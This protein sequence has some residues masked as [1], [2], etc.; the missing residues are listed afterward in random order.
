MVTVHPAEAPH[1]LNNHGADNPRDL[2]TTFA[3][4][5]AI[6]GCNNINVMGDVLLVL[7][8]EHA[9]IIAGAGW[10]KNDVRSYLYEL[11]RQP[12]SLLKLGGIHGRH[13]HRN[14]LW[15]RWIDRS[16]D[17]AMVPVV[18]RAGGY[19]Y[20]GGRRAGPSFGL[21]PRLGFADYFG[22]SGL[23]HSDGQDGQDD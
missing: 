17:D 13:T 4:S 21:Y 5:M 6:P 18:R 1:N 8:P 10:S 16:D 11:A 3:V 12:L 23:T 20:N 2:L 14:T 19:S 9:E 7:G 15:P 22:A